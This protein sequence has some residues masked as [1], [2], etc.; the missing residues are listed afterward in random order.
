M[1]EEVPDGYSAGHRDVERVLCAALGNFEAHVALVD[2]FLGHTL[3]LVAEYDGV[4]SPRLRSELLQLDA[5]LHLLETAES[6]SL[7]LE[8]LYAGICVGEILPAHRILRPES[9]LVDFGRRRTRADAA[10]HQPL[11]GK[12]VAGAEY[13]PDI[14]EAA[15]IVEHYRERHFG[16][17]SEVFDVRTV[18]V[19]DGFLF[20]R[21]ILEEQN[22]SKN[23][24]LRIRAHINFS[25]VRKR[26]RSYKMELAYCN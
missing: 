21:H 2:D 19:A 14:V 15:D 12:S 7:A 9:C 8:G 4:A 6:V 1:L 22:Y 10:E 20:H 17:T 5:P 23:F 24:R 16:L 18:K 11:D 13:G 26:N 25:V 3:D